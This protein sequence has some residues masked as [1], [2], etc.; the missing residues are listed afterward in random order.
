MAPYDNTQSDALH[1]VKA[2]SRTTI[3]LTLATPLTHTSQ[4]KKLQELPEYLALVEKFTTS[5]IM[6]WA[7]V[8]SV[9]A[10]ILHSTDGSCVRVRLVVAHS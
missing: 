8:E 10:G 7:D 4:L 5:E 2:V 6:P 3:T 9:F 1:R